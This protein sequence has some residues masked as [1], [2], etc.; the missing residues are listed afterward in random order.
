M[1]QEDYYN[2]YDRCGAE[3]YEQEKYESDKHE[4]K[5]ATPLEWW[6]R[7]DE[8]LDHHTGF[9]ISDRFYEF[10]APTKGVNPDW[11]INF[12]EII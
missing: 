10:N 9:E 1:G 5:K 11:Y 8:G 6:D 2:G 3:D 7:V 4:F 12:W